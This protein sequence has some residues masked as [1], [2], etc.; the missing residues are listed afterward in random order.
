MIA[1]EKKA[2]RK[3]PQSSFLKN[4][5]L[6]LSLYCWKNCCCCCCP[7]PSLPA[8]SA[9]AP[10]DLLLPLS[11]GSELGA[12]TG[13]GPQ[14]PRRILPKQK[15][16]RPW[17]RRRACGQRPP[18]APPAGSRRARRRARRRPPMARGCSRHVVDEDAARR[19]RRLL[20]FGSI[21]VSVIPRSSGVLRQT[22]DVAAEAADDVPSP[23]SPLRALA[24][25]SQQARR[26]GGMAGVVK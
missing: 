17:A 15:R 19:R 22:A 11:R 23:G 12:S 9:A 5:K 18:P 6:S 4:K 16:R 20:L 26:S 13:R 7:S 8:P 24:M 10:L 1:Q 14:L 3:H 21:F 25:N 2:E